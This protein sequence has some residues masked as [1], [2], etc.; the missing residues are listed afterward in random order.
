M[1]AIGLPKDYHIKGLLLVHEIWVL[2]EFYKSC[3]KCFFEKIF[4]SLILVR[5]LKGKKLGKEVKTLNVIRYL[6]MRFEN[7]NGISR[8]H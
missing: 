6:K 1:V 8:K 4:K 7:L 5:D 2:G 3:I